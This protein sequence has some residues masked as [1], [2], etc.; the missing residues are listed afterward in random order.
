LAAKL[1]ALGI[2]QR[3]ALRRRAITRAKVR[4]PMCSTQN[5]VET[6]ELDDPVIVPDVVW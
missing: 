6:I 4:T 5:R 2:A 3:S 1:D